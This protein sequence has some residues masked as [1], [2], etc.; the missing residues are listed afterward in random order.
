MSF[1]RFIP[2]LILVACSPVTQTENANTPIWSDEF[3]YSGAPDPEKWSY[4]MG[5][6]CPRVCGWGNNEKQIYTADRENVRVENGTL[7]IEAHKEDDAY[8]SAR[9]VTKNKGDW[10]TGVI[11]VRA[12]LPQALGTWPA[13]WMLPTLEKSQWPKDGEIDIMEHVGFNHGMVYGTIHTEKFNHTK[14]T[15]KID[16]IKVSEVSDSFHE[17]TLEWTDEEMI[18]KVD[19]TVYNRIKRNG[20]DYGGWPFDNP[21]HLILNVAVGGNW[22]GKHGIDSAAFPQQM[23]V[24]YVRVYQ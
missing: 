21:F 20:E 6:G 8:S 19:D 13:I 11:K 5:D 22:G 7:I 16:S 14:G 15:Q 4:D 23:V 10:N 18:W 24:D 9:L 1:L 2:A 3:E 12:K 17:Y